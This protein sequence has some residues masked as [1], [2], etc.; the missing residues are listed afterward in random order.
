MKDPADSNLDQHPP[1]LSFLEF[2]ADK[3]DSEAADHAKAS[4]AEAKA[5][6]REKKC[7]ILTD[8]YLT[9]RGLQ[10]MREY[11]D[12]TRAIARELVDA[13]QVK[14]PKKGDKKQAHKNA[15]RANL[16]A[17]VEQNWL[18]IQ[19]NDTLIA[20]L[21]QLDQDLRTATRYIAQKMDSTD[22]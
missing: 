1:I 21:H 5:A 3:T 9:S 12:Q 17:V 10:N 7:Q 14:P 4:K 6:A 16:K 11:A 2:D 22:A 19:Q 13:T 15:E 18:L 20:V 8:A